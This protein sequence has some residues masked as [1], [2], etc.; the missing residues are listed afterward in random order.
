MY[1]VAIA[2]VNKKRFLGVDGEVG[3]DAR[4]VPSRRSM[5]R[6]YLIPRVGHVLFAGCGTW[7][8]DETS[9][10]RPIIHIHFSWA[11]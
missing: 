6:L 1:D 4:D 8:G 3:I 9:G 7:S 11:G 2:V 5:S 10:H